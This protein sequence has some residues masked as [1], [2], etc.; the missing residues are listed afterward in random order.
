MF[1]VY[2]WQFITEQ[3]VPS[4]TFTTK[5]EAWAYVK[6]QIASG[7]DMSRFRV[8]APAGL[9]LTDA[10]ILAANAQFGPLDPELVR[11]ARLPA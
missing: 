7:K 4:R 9:P 1:T 5:A 3:F 10:E 8:E 11:K 6:A 2:S